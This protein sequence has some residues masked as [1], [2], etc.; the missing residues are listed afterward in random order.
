MGRK[1]QRTREELRRQ[2]SS[3]TEQENTLF[4]DYFTAV[5]AQLNM[6]T[7][8]H[9]PCKKVP[10]RWVL[11]Y[12]SSEFRK[13]GVPNR[14]RKKKCGSLF[15]RNMDRMEKR[16]EGDA[17]MQ[18]GHNVF[19]LI[20]Y[21]AYPQPSTLMADFRKCPQNSKMHKGKEQ[22]KKQG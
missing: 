5:R 19:S 4:S 12:L 9:S 15:S 7:P 8:A 18:H 20:S 14:D 13:K 17:V 2:Q 16:T 1:R 10:P 6:P 3:D 11:C 21:P 22:K